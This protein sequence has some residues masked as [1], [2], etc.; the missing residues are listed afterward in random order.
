MRILVAVPLLLLAS[1]AA[2]QETLI[3][4]GVRSRPDYD[5]ASKQETDLIP[6]VRWYGETWFARTTQGILE[7]GARL[8]LAPR[9]WAGAQLAFEEGNDRTDLDPGASWGLHGEWDTS[10]GPAPISVLARTRTHFDADRGS[11]ADLRAT[12]GVYGH[13]GLFVALFGAVYGWLAMQRE[14]DQPVLWLGLIGK[15]GF[16][17]LVATFWMR[18]VVHERLVIAASADMAF[19]AF[20]FWWL[21]RARFAATEGER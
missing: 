12:V 20:W 5:G 7:G 8:E 1:L 4:A 19:A 9:L 18:A 2:A 13:A 15:A 16:F 10:V 6:V 11:Q 3:G 17:V 14:L 21:M